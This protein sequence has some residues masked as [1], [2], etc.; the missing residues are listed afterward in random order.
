MGRC[1]KKFN[2]QKTFLNYFM[3]LKDF[4]YYCLYIKKIL[5]SKD[6]TKALIYQSISEGEY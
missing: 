4:V 2:D 6:L 3:Q 1:L 5:N